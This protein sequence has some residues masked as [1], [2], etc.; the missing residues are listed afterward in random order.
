MKGGVKHQSR[1]G[2]RNDEEKKGDQ[3]KLEGSVR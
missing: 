1:R 3:R 2:E